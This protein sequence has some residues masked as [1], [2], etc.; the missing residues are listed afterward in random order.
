[1]SPHT[2]E[3]S[4][5]LG[6]SHFSFRDCG[7]GKKDSAW[8]TTFK[9]PDHFNDYYYKNN[10]T[11]Y[12]IKVK[13]P[14]MIEKLKESF[15]NR[16]EKMVVVALAV[17]SNGTIDGY[18]GSDLQINSK[19]IQT[20]ISILNLNNIFVTRRSTGERSKN[21][22]I[23][24]QKKI[25]KYIKDGS[26]GDLILNST[27]TLGDLTSV[28]GRLVLNNCNFKSLENLKSVTSLEIRNCPN[29]KSLNMLKYVNILVIS[30]TSIENLGV[31]T[32]AEM[33][34]IQHCPNLESLGNIKS[35]KYIRIMNC[36]NLK[37]L[38]KLESVENLF[39]QNCPI[40]TFGELKSVGENLN[41]MQTPLSKKH[42]ENEIRKM[43]N[44]GGDIKL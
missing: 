21:H 37:S 41:I 19:D 27:N 16:W 3:A 10:V 36:L 4:R 18:N 2:H 29:L 15:P 13:S 28:D 22:Q 31:V 39:I 34:D 20:F 23:A 1:M 42:N 30:E 40:K 8:C 17:L 26:K 5:K 35:A 9:S 38:G 33:I 12:Y 32:F 25:Q 44:V 11:F 14:Q 6:L 43:I 24:E 7:N